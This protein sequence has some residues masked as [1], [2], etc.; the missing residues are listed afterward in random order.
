M[1]GNPR[2]GAGDSSPP[3]G[4]MGK[5][6]A[7]AGQGRTGLPGDFGPEPE[8]AI[9][10]RGLCRGRAMVG[11]WALES[12]PGRLLRLRFGAAGGI[13]SGRIGLPEKEATPC[14][15]LGY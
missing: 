7:G 14:Q 2:F 15:P 5:P 9:E 6:L 11:R 10:V 1:P 4:V 12:G 3:S 13:Q 8:G